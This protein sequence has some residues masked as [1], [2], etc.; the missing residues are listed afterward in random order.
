MARSVEEKPKEATTLPEPA[1][2]V[3]RRY[4]PRERVPFQPLQVGPHL[5][6]M[7]ISQISVFFQRLLQ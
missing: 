3:D 7:L 2:R 4:R 5:R 1:A 6:G